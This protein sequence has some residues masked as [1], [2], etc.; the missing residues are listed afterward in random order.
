MAWCQG[1]AA[2]G[3][4]DGDVVDGILTEFKMLEKSGAATG[5][6]WFDFAGRAREAGEL[7]VA[8]QALNRAEKEQFSP[9]RIGVERT[10]I[11]VAGGNRDAAV[12]EIQK[13]LD[14][15]FT[16]VSVLTGD[17]VINSM[18][19][20]PDYDA[21]ISEMSK[22]AYP[23]QFMP[24]FREFDFWIGEWDVNIANG[25]YAGSNSIQ[26]AERGCLLLEN[27]SS[28]TGGTGQSINYLD[29]ATGEW[30]QVWNA[31]GGS[32][33]NIR[34]GLTDEGMLLEGTIHY[35]ANG[36]TAPFRALF[37]PLPDGRVRQ[38]FEQSNDGGD[39]W[40]TWFEGF[41]SRKSD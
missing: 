23:C 5:D 24:E 8:A 20:T 41:Y 39:T 16:S 14:A 32:Q 12:K 11:S 13:I 33:I 4:A 40:F 22:Q 30:V 35:V 26:P 18:A 34:G 6:N 29:K 38:F 10:R 3:K 19:G 27:W 37:T 28:A 31:E 36:T 25:T 17:P 15:G 21:V 2:Q 1:V 9:I 7:D